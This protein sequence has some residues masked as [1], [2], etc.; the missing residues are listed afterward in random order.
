MMY[1]NEDKIIMWLSSFEFLSYKKIKA[2][3][4]NFDD[5]EDLFDCL[6]DY[7][8]DLLKIIKLEEYVS[9]KEQR[10]LVL[11]ER[12][13]AEYEKL[14]IKVLT[15]KS[16][17]YPELLKETDAPPIM[18]YCRGNIDLL[19]TECLAVV[20]T[21]RATNYG[22][23]MC[24]KI[25]NDVALQGITIVSGLADGIDTVAHKSTLEVN[26]KTIAVLGA[27]LLNIYPSSNEGLYNDIIKNGGLI[28]SEY[29]PSEPVVTYHF[30]VRN[31]II[32]GLSKATFVV[33]AGEKSGSMHTKNYALDYGRE[34]FAL[35]ARVNDIYSVGCNKLIKCGQA[36]MALS[37]EDF[38]EFFGGA[39]ID[40]GVTKTI[41][42]SFDE[43]KIYD[44]LDLNELAVD[45]LTL[46]TGLA[47]K[48][49]L[50]LLMRMEIK[51]II[52]KLPGNIYTIDR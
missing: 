18:L 12:A 3:I 45:E 46:K 35:P 44:E 43:Q 39:N 6:D 29:K 49:L 40:G 27:G 22:K 7:K 37:A 26:G 31:R 13:I 32:A 42:L 16:M 11:V 9:I 52:K 15:I 41:E 2:I 38:M 36:R 8:A 19:K 17:E 5:I 28:I 21:R 23:T 33:E 50:T 14:D 34:V 48:I 30:P 20:G 25:V 24:K 4:D 1:T 47:P 51:G 10:N